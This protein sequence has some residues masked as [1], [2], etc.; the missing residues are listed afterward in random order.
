MRKLHFI[1]V[2]ILMIATVSCK[3]EKNQNDTPVTPISEEKKG[4]YIL[5]E[6]T[7]TYANSSLSY[8][9][10]EA[11]TVGN[12]LFFKTNGSPIGDVGQ[13][14]ALY[15]GSLY[16]VVNGSKYIYKV[17]AETLKF[18]AKLEGF[19]SPRNIHVLENGLAYVSDLQKDG[20]WLIDLNTMEHRQF[21]ETGNS[22]EAMVRVGDELF[23]SNWSN[24]YVPNSSNKSVQVIDM[25]TNT[26]VETIDVPQE[27]NAMVV[28]K[29]D[30]IWVLC[31]GG[32]NPGEQEPALVCVDAA[33]RQIVK[34][35]DF[36]AGIDY[37]DGLAIDGAGENLYYLNGGYNNLN[38]YKMS[39]DAAQVP[40]N[41]FIAAEGCVFYNVAVDPENGDVYVT[42]AKNYVQNGDVERF[43]KDGELLSKFT[44]GI[45]PCYMLFN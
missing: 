29:N 2:A 6:G 44:V 1:I 43:T 40:D 23:V 34:R 17:D 12:N 32:Y 24:Y 22:T 9:D 33:K 20:L 41:P 18:Q 3:K 16:I 36:N 26:L 30:N 13:S 21:I 5:N 10:K 15:D 14:L 27:P 42:N 7:F 8:Y 45:V 31:S 39:V 11:D 37:P 25:K 35:F 19:A 38:V 28:D 4:V